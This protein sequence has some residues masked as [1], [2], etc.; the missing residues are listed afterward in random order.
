MAMTL[1]EWS[2]AIR[3]SVAAPT[4]ASETELTRLK[5]YADAE[6][7]RYGGAGAPEAVRDEASVLLGGYLW[8]GPGGADLVSAGRTVQALRNSGAAAMLAPY[9]THRAGVIGA[10]VADAAIGGSAA[11]N[12]L[13]GVGLT[14]MTLAFLFADGRTLDIELP[15][16][17]SGGLTEDQRRELSSSVPYDGITLSGGDLDVVSHGGDANTIDLAPA[18]TPEIATWA[19]T[20]NPAGTVPLNRIPPEI[21]R[22]AEIDA[23]IAPWA[24]AGEAEPSNEELS[25]IAALPDV[26]NDD[27]AGYSPGDVVNLAG[28]LYRLTATPVAET[29]T[30]T[31]T[32]TYVDASNGDGVFQWA[33]RLRFTFTPSSLTGIPPTV[34][35]T[36]GARDDAILTRAG[37]LWQTASSRSNINPSRPADGAQFTVSL[38]TNVARTVALD[39]FTVPA[40]TRYAW[41]EA[42][43]TGIDQ[44]GVDARV[45]AGTLP[46][47]RAGNADAIP[48]AKLANAPKRTLAEVDAR[49]AT[50][51]RVNAPSGTIPDDRIPSTIARDS[52][53]PTNA[54][55]D[56]RADARVNA[57]I[58]ANRRIPAYA[59]GDANE[60]LAVAADGNSLRFVPQASG[61]GGGGS[62]D[63]LSSRA[64]LPAVA[65]FSAGDIVNRGGDLYE[66]LASTDATNELAEAFA[67]VG[68]VGLPANYVGS[69][70]FHWDADPPGNVRAYLSKAVLGMNPPATIYAHV[71]AQ[72]GI[73]DDTKLTRSS[74]SDTATSY[75]YF[76][77]SDGGKLPVSDATNPVGGAFVVR[78]FTDA[79][80]TA[81]QAVHNAARWARWDRGGVPVSLWAQA[82][83]DE[84]L[85]LAKLP[86]AI[87]K[88]NLPADV[89]YTGDIPHGVGTTYFDEQFPGLVIPSTLNNRR[90]AAPAYFANPAL[91]LDDH[92]HGEFHCSL[93]AVLAPVS[94]V[95]MA[96]VKTT[97]ATA[98]QR[99]RTLSNIVFASDLAEEGAFVFANT[100][101]LEGLAIFELPIFS[102]ETDVGTYTVLLVRNAA[103][104]VGVYQFYDGK[105]GATGATITAELRVTFTP[106]DAPAATPAAALEGTVIWTKRGR[107]T[108]GSAEATNDEA[109]TLR[110]ARVI[111]WYF[112]FGGDAAEL[113]W[114]LIGRSVAAETA[115]NRNVE[116]SRVVWWGRRFLTLIGYVHSSGGGG[117]IVS[118]D[119]STP[120][121]NPLP[122]N[123]WYQARKIA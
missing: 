74:G 112:S 49:I 113:N 88:A 59:L 2:I 103:K 66:L 82:G 73:N 17:G 39:V 63:E 90:P 118:V 108:N 4:G 52:E 89:A 72:S 14:D 21:A 78:F 107:A 102:N 106:S 60:V 27:P 55:I 83:S 16:A 24:R 61:G 25:V 96:F 119:T 13:V 46:W 26:A 35:A 42:G 38:W 34:Y 1:T 105:S 3:A 62:S 44:A 40:H 36:V 47:A 104:Q 23:Y 7:L 71:Q 22:D 65:G 99:R 32:G 92:P 95:N 10:A 93:E 87:P 30:N 94:D 11:G 69:P 8:D 115:S 43:A 123:V 116:V 28:T 81:P 91:D 31:Y 50:F 33:N 80:G 76:R 122:G 18:I 20:S 45:V 85:P 6:A 48:G 29:T 19:R 15:S 109:A 77:A 70:A 79:L 114:L 51:A 41:E 111:D 120:I 57:L 98:A 67:P 37:N 5:A 68:T 9:R 58:P 121:T 97:N 56:A 110:A 100:A 12:P 117:Q 64:A 54:A 75:A 53:V 84:R 86:A 101:D